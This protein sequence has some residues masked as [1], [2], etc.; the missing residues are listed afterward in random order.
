MEAINDFRSL[1]PAP[2]D[3][4]YEN[5]W[6]FGDTAVVD[7]HVENLVAFV[8]LITNTI[9]GRKYIGK[10]IFTFTNRVKR[11]GKKR[12][13]IKKK[14]SDWKKYYGSS[15]ELLADLEQQGPLTFKRD[16]L[17]LCHSKKQASYY[18]IQEMIDRRVLTDRSYYNSN[19]LGKFFPR[20][21][22]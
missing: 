11:A 18:E 10:K 7:A 17:W 3:L 8:Y 9:N 12:R 21:L 22:T 16:I 15:E 14:P 1:T 5:P 13:V 20:D 19:I 2:N 6:M 4:D